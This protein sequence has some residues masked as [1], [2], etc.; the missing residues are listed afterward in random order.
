MKGLYGTACILLFSAGC[1]TLPKVHTE[2]TKV[3]GHAY[4]S[5]SKDCE[6]QILTQ[7]PVDRRYEELAILSSVTDGGSF[8]HKDL[9][10]ML[11]SIKAKACE[12]GADAIV[13]KNVEQGGTPV[14]DQY[15][16]QMP[17]RVYCV[18]IKFLPM[19]G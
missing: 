13:I 18:A 19:A 11:P 7:T 12:L 3:T 14:G 10:S 9:N 8:T 6:I 17:T 1:T 5:R 15:G 16:H 2:V 4:Q